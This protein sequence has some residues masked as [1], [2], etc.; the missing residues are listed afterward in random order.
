M[1]RQ[2]FY[3]PSQGFLFEIITKA[4]VSKHLKKCAM[5]GGMSNIVNIA[6]T[7]TFLAGAHPLLRRSFRSCKICFERRHARVY[8]KY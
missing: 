3:A 4:E 2:K 8:D 7:D 6:G 1:L 5:S